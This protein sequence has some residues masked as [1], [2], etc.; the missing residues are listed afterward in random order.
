MELKRILAK[1][2][3]RATEK[4]VALYGQDVLFVSNSRVNGMTEVIVAVDVAYS[5]AASPRSTDQDGADRERVAA[6][7]EMAS[8]GAREAIMT[9]ENGAF[10]SLASSESGNS[11]LRASIKIWT[12]E[13]LLFSMSAGVLKAQG[14]PNALG[15]ASGDTFIG[16][17]SQLQID[18]LTAATFEAIHLNGSGIGG[19][20]DLCQCR[21][22]QGQ[23]GAG[24]KQQG[25]SVGRHVSCSLLPEPVF[26]PAAEGALLYTISPTSKVPDTGAAEAL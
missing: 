25:P 14:N 1:D 16:S 10:A 2:I 3:R 19:T 20:G 7:R 21:L 18:S 12:P 9:V 5:L 17:G 8:L 23:A 24:R 6:V 22:A 13:E 4:A 11:L 26:D 15:N